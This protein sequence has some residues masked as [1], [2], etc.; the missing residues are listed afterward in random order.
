M[1]RLVSFL[2]FYLSSTNQ[3]GVHSPFVYNYV[4][5][6]LY[7]K[8][9]IKLP[10]AQKLLIKSILYFDY[11]KIQ[12]LLN[13]INLEKDLRL[14]CPKISFSNNLPD[15][16]FGS[17]SEFKTSNLNFSRQ[18]NNAMLL[19]DGIHQNKKNLAYWNSLKKDAAVQVTIDMFYC[20]VIFFRKEQVKEHFKIRI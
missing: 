4:T 2:K 13:D 20:G 11:V 1:F 10:I 7:K 8:K 16:I 3:H 5:K 12:L 15:V 18:K 17:A 6:C 14:S 19:I 9:K